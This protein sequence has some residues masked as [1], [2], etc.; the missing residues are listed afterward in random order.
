MISVADLFEELSSSNCM[1]CNSQGVHDDTGN[2]VFIDC[3]F[4]AKNE[5]L[6]FVVIATT[7]TGSCIIRDSFK[8]DDMLPLTLT[9][10]IICYDPCKE[11]DFYGKFDVE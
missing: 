1:S 10:G 11:D 6:R 4:A 8:I 2:D 5:D 9:R 7:F 3:H